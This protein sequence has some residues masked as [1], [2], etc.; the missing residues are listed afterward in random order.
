MDTVS[1]SLYKLTVTTIN[2][3]GQ[4]E[5]LGI[6]FGAGLGIAISVISSWIKNHNEQKEK[7]IRA[8]KLIISNIQA[9]ILVAANNIGIVSNEL[10][11]LPNTFTLDPIQAFLPSAADLLLLTS[12]FKDKNC[13]PLWSA[14]K[15]AEI[16]SSQAYSIHNET[17]ALKRAIKCETRPEV[18]QFELLPHLK[19]LDQLLVSTMTKISVEYQKAYELTKSLKS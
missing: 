18:Y 5:I 8:A 15:S 14:L 4:K 10:N 2:L 7:N 6:I 1:D 11:K 13:F 3:I 19:Q 9:N 16:L 17:L 12:S